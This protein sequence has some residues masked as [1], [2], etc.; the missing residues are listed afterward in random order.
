M[1]SVIVEER[2][3]R[4]S[5]MTHDMDLFFLIVEE[6]QVII[7]VEVK[8]PE[9]QIGVKLGLLIRWDGEMEMGER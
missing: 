8:S 2:W 6:N 9:P 3:G 1:M 4:I 7:D 5:N